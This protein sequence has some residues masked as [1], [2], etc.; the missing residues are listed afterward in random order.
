MKLANDARTRE[1]P[2]NYSFVVSKNLIINATKRWQNP[3]QVLVEEIYEIL[4]SLVNKLVLKHFG[5][6]AQGGLFNKIMMTISDILAKCHENTLK[7]VRWFLHVEQSVFTLNEHYLADYKEKFLKY[8][9]NLRHG[10]FRDLEITVD[11]SAVAFHIMASVR[12]YFQVAYKRFC[13]NI[14]MV[15]DQELIR[16]LD[17]NS[18]HSIQGTLLKELGVSGSDSQ[19]ICKDLLQEPQNVLSRREELTQRKARLEKAKEQLMKVL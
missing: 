11:P 8:Y 14:P 17:C 7:Y 15:I 3:S 6:Y 5:N 18:N 10:R 4:T 12:A 1:L 2:D 13:D 16:G 19:K 9:L